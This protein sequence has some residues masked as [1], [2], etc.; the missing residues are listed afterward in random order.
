MR[1]LTCWILLI[2]SFIT[3]TAQDINL[4]TAD[5]TTHVETYGQGLPLLIING[6]PGMNS[7]GFRGLA[8]T[9]GEDY[10]TIIYDQRGTGQSAIYPTDDQTITMDKM[11]EDIEQIREHLKLKKWI[12]LGH[13]F[14]GMLASYYATKHPERIEG[15]ILSSSGGINLEVFDGNHI[16][17]NKRLSQLHQDSLAYWNGQIAAGDTSYHARLR[18]GYHLGPAYLYDQSYI[19][20][21]AK[22]LTQGNMVING[23]VF[24]NMRKIDFN[25]EEKLTDF[26]APV[27]IIQGKEDILDTYLSEYAHKVFPNSTLIL[28]DACAHYGWLDQ[29]EKYFSALKT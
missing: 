14:G 7:V 27:L 15:M 23:L 26:E 21:I 25:C 28:L 16:H 13:S 5:G 4:R 3:A 18:R 12:V 9:L 10:R 20:V 1:F 8:R 6:G 24:Q 17:V 22:R 29:P 11:V 2:V 19:D